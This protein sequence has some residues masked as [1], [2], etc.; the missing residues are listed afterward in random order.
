MSNPEHTPEGT[1]LDINIHASRKSLETRAC[2]GPD[3][4]DIGVFATEQNI[5]WLVGS[6]TWG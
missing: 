6:F 4:A 2:T 3:S 1:D 5:N